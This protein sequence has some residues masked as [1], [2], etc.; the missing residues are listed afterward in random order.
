MTRVAQRIR[1]FCRYLMLPSAIFIC[2]SAV[3]A[4]DENH[5]D[6]ATAIPVEQFA[7]HGQV[8]YV[9]RE[10]V[11]FNAPYSGP[12]SLSPDRGKETVDAT[13]ILGARLWRGAE[14]WITPEIDQGFGLN[15]T[16]GVAGFPSG[17]AYKVG[18]NYPY[19]RWPRVFVRQTIDEGSEREAVSILQTWQIILL[20]VSPGPLRCQ[21][22]Q[23]HHASGAADIGSALRWLAPPTTHNP[24]G[25]SPQR[26]TLESCRSVEARGALL[27]VE[28]SKWLAGPAT[29]AR[30]RVCSM[31]TFH[32]LKTFA[33]IS[34]SLFPTGSGTVR[35]VEFHIV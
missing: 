3:N 9:E 19:L 13:L 25:A 24:N 2:T 33:L 29:A 30:G 35:C 28:D 27:H 17:E 1:Y 31:P 22:H 34:R 12:N 23:R 11:G 18:A 5:S 10:T 6:A 26:S 15:N 14:I 8:T 16:L 20:K 21:Q 7:I 4:A 32:L